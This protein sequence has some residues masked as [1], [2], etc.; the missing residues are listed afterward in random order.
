MITPISHGQICRDT[1]RE[2]SV[3]FAILIDPGSVAMSLCVGAVF[4]ATALQMPNA[5]HCT[6]ALQQ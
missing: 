3:I 4:V 1:V 5:R 6:I 2:S